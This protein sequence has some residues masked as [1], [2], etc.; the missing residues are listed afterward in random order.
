[1]AATFHITVFWVT[2]YSPDRARN[3]SAEH[4]ASAFRGPHTARRSCTRSSPISRVGVRRFISGIGYRLF[5]RCPSLPS[6]Q[7]QTIRTPTTAVSFLTLLNSLIF[8]P[9]HLI[10]SQLLRNQKISREFPKIEKVCF[11]K[12]LLPRQ[13]TGRHNSEHSA[14]KETYKFSLSYMESTVDLLRI[15]PLILRLRFCPSCV[16]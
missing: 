9:T 11:S 14:L 8:R 15:S 10:A 1:M 13:I 3:I 4:T 16:H 12:S 2:S 6:A 5:R 7:H